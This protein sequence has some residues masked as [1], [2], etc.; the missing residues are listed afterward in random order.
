MVTDSLR[1]LPDGATFVDLGGGRRCDYAAAVPRDRAVRLVVV[2]ISAEELTH[3]TDADETVVADVA[4]GLPFADGEVDLL[5]SRTL[6]EHVDGVASAIQHMARAMKPGGRTIHLMPGRYALFALAARLLP[7]GP[8]LGMLHFAMPETTGV[9][10]FE[11]RY[12]HTEPVAIKRLFAEAGFR[13]V[14]IEW[15]AGQA[16]YFKPFIPAYLLVIAYEALVRFFG[17]SRLAAYLIVSAERPGDH[18][19]EISSRRVS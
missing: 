15:T 3:N 13:N 12:D 10:E 14:R 16:D 6:L 8:L 19:N 4:K 9:V 17:V 1:A 5:V 2:D 11:V 18:D 7:F